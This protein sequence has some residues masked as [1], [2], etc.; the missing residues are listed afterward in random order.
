[1]IK[2]HDQPEMRSE[3]GLLSRRI[4]TSPEFRAYKEYAGEEIEEWAETFNS[5]EWSYPYSK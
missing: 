4:N 3:K 1:M 5:S 2:S